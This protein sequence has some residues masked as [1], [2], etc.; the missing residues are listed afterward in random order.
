MEYL[1]GEPLA[2]RLARRPLGRDESV[3]IAIDVADALDAAHRH[4]LIQG[5]EVPPRSDVFVLVRRSM[6]C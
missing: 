5:R 4:S 1:E 2:T 6:R 3:R